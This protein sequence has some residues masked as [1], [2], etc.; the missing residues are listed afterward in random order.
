MSTR[1]FNVG[2]RV[3]IAAKHAWP[4][5]GRIATVV[6]EYNGE[7]YDVFNPAI[8]GKV[9]TY[10]LDIDQEHT[11]PPEHLEPYYDGDEPV[12]WADCVWKPAGV[13]A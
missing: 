3:R 8:R 12:S 9:L 4:L 7:S 13:S 6:R 5:N 11:Y 1:K 10:D 2:D